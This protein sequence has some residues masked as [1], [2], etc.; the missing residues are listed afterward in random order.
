MKKLN[1]NPLTEIE[2]L[3]YELLTILGKDIL[4]GRFTVHILQLEESHG[5]IVYTDYGFKKR[6]EI[7]KERVIDEDFFKTV[8]HEFFHLVTTVTSVMKD[9]NP[10]ALDTTDEVY[11]ETMAYAFSNIFENYEKIVALQTGIEAMILSYKQVIG[12]K[13]ND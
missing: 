10:K 3:L 2:K 9:G 13:E 1:M 6:F 7:D 5:R 11:A 4:V 12:Y 8:Y